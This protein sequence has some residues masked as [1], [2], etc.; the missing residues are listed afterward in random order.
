MKGRRSA[1]KCAQGHTECPPTCPERRWK[2]PQDTFGP[3][4]RDLWRSQQPKGGEPDLSAA[5]RVLLEEACRLADRL[6]TLDQILRGDTMAWLRVS[7]PEGSDVGTLIVDKALSEARQQQVALKTLLA[8]LRQSR[9]TRS[10]RPDAGK[11]TPADDH[12]DTSNVASLTARIAARRKAASG[13]PPA[14]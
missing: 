4:G 8:E 2:P 11:D 12:G 3:R 13:N 5:E 10:P 9:A 14:L 1:R 6:D 7:V